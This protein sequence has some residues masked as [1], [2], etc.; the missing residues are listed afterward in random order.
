VYRVKKPEIGER[1]EGHVAVA[2]G[3]VEHERPVRALDWA[4]HTL[5]AGLMSRVTKC[6]FF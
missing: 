4:Q 1:D 5:R 2:D 6:F 3:R